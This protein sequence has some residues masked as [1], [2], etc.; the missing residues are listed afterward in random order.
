MSNVVT[1]VNVTFET[2]NE[3]YFLS[4]ENILQLLVSFPRPSGAISSFLCF[5]TVKQGL[6]QPVY[7]PTTLENEIHGLVTSDRFYV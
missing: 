3:K 1:V 4:G 2:L 5:T 7:G 6:G